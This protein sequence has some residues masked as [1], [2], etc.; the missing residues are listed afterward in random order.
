MA[1]ASFTDADPAPLMLRAESAEDLTIISALVQDAILPV[2]EIIYDPRGRRLALLINRFRW[3]DRDQAERAGRAYERVQALLVISDVLRVQSDGI[4][5]KDADLILSL[6]SIE[7]QPG[8]DGAGRVLLT[9]AG[10]GQ[11]SVTAECID[12]DLRDVTR[13]YVAPSGHVPHHPD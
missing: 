5:R 4:D 11:I 1:D 8:E 9:F 3:E 12:I 6:L 10:D 7:W 2:T 13:P